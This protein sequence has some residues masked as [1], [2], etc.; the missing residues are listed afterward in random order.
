MGIYNFH[1]WL[2]TNFNGSYIPIKGNNIYEYIYIDVNYML[3]NSMYGCANEIEF[4]RKLYMQFDVIFANFI[5]TKQIYFS[6]DGPSS[7]AKILLQRKRR[8]ENSEKINVDSISSLY[9]TPGTTHMQRIEKHIKTYA[10][11]LKS[12]Y[13]YF[14]PQITLATSNEPDEGE[15]K[16]CKELIKNGKHNLN[17]RHLIIGNDSDLIALSMGMK[18]IYNINILVRSK[19]ENELI[20]LSNL[21]KLH[22][23]KLDRCD[24][25]DKICNSYI[26]DDFIIVSIMMG[27]DYFP[28]MGFINADKIW[29][30][31]YTYMSDFQDNETLIM[32]GEFNV[33]I[34]GEF[35]LKIYNSLLSGYKIIDTNTYNKLKAESY[36]TGLLWCLNMYSTGMCPCYEYAYCY[37]SPHPYEL[38]FHI[39]SNN[40]VLNKSTMKP[41]SPEIYPLIVMPKR[42]INFIPKKFHT[43]MNNELKYLYE[44]ENCSECLR[45]K[46]KISEIKCQISSAIDKTD[47]ISETNETDEADKTSET[48]DKQILKQSHHNATESYRNHKKV[49]VNHF[50]PDDIYKI[51]NLAMKI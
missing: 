43:L 49:H 13:K 23:R 15:I 7:F 45:Y 4:I 39:Y 27:N 51:I 12:K 6:I 10:E 5:A 22:A 8:T 38:L 36:L 37:N 31:Y 47:E 20:S 35:L 29:K 24:K 9:L 19:G 11:R 48:N 41:I 3:H 18:P 40:V 50:N 26:R 46:Q 21:L 2:R 14:S 25:L 17:D 33:E 16:I 28:K 34:F 30:I 44:E 1:T 42:A 32:N